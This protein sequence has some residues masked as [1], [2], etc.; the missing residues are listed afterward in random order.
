MSTVD[1]NQQSEVVQVAAT[2]VPPHF[3]VRQIERPNVAR[4]SFWTVRQSPKPF[5]SSPLN[6][7][8]TVVRGSS[9]RHSWLTA[10]L[11]CRLS[12]SAKDSVPQRPVPSP[13]ITFFIR[14]IQ[15]GDVGTVWIEDSSNPL[16]FEAG[17]KFDNSFL[18]P[19]MSFILE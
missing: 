12:S 17:H 18:C 6:V 2:P 7:F 9:G 14:S 8:R 13:I 15:F 1:L 4:H 10:E 3:Q 5:Y 19:E 11:S 16:T